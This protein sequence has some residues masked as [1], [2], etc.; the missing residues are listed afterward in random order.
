M[1]DSEL[2]VIR[3]PQKMSQYEWL[4]SIDKQDFSNSSVLLIGAGAMA[5]QFA[6]TLHQMNISQVTILSRNKDRVVDLSKQYGYKPL[7]G[8]YEKHLQHLEPFDIVIVSTPIDL[9]IPVTE[10]SIETGQTNILVEKPVSVDHRK[11]ESLSKKISSQKVRVGYN[12]LAYPNFHKLKELANQ[13]GGITSAKYSFTEW[14]HAIDFNKY[15]PEVLQR[16][17]IANSLHVISMAHELIG[18]PF[19]LKAQQSGG[20]TWHS[21]GTIFTGVGLAKNNIPFSYHSDW[22]APGRWGIEIMTKEYAYRLIPLELLSR[23]PKGSVK[24]E[25]VSFDSAYPNA[26]QGLAEEI[27]IM[28]T[29]STKDKPDLPTLKKATAF[30]ELAERIFGYST[31]EM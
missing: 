23:C 27:S 24:W 19:E 17:G 28:L 21:S 15:T 16:W 3:W 11:I 31:S 1:S 7:S 5:K 22:T 10:L 14:I 12:R 20:L 2:L 30:C 4:S 18:M 6:E 9:L 26:K 13:E 8:G 29:E 25:D